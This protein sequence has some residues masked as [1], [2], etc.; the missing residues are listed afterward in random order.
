LTARGNVG[1]RLRY[2]FHSF[3]V[4]VEVSPVGGFSNLRA[5]RFKLLHPSDVERYVSLS[6]QGF[7]EER[8]DLAGASQFVAVQLAQSV[9]QFGRYDKL[10]F[11]AFYIL[12]GDYCLSNVWAGLLSDGSSP[13]TLR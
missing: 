3:L 6:F 2:Q 7:Q 13:Q 10:G 12:E 5:R 1:Y 11:Y 9:Y 8:I 4:L